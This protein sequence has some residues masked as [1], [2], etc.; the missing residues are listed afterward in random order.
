MKETGRRRRK[1]NPPCDPSAVQKAQSDV[2]T[3]QPCQPRLKRVDYLLNDLSALL[4]APLGFLHFLS[5]RT[6]GIL[7]RFPS[8]GTALLTRYVC[9]ADQSLAQPDLRRGGFSSKRSLGLR[10]TWCVRRVLG[11]TEQSSQGAPERV[12]HP[13]ATW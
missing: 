10:S 2:P 12:Q 11:R 5:I 8:V 3:T 1:A 7:L 9:V 4:A 13:S 6:L